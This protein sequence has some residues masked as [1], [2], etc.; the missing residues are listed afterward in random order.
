MHATNSI[1]FFL[2]T[3]RNSLT[4]NKIN[5]ILFFINVDIWQCRSAFLPDQAFGSVQRDITFIW[6]F[7]PS[8]LHLQV[9]CSCHSHDSHVLEGRKRW[10]FPETLI[11]HQFLCSGYRRQVCLAF[12]KPSCT[13]WQAANRAE[14][15]NQYISIMFPDWS[16]YTFQLL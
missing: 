16:G 5:E 13:A 9:L 12:Q 4:Y 3:M 14:T 8:S 11:C 10:P 1:S 7:F 2:G 15:S 6:L